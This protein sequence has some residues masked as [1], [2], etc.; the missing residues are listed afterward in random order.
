[1]LGLVVW[2]SAFFVIGI[3]RFNRRYV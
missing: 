3:W 1:V 2:G